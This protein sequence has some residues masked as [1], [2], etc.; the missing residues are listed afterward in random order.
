MVFLLELIQ[1]SALP[2]HRFVFSLFL[3]QSRGQKT[4]RNLINELGDVLH[5]CVTRRKDGP[6]VEQTPTK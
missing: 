5:W 6:H 3:I 4:E 1:H 2:I